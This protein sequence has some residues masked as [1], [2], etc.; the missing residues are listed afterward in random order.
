[1]KFRTRERA[2][3]RGKI[4]FDSLDTVYYT[5]NLL[6]NFY[7]L[8]DDS[9]EMKYLLLFFSIFLAIVGQFFLKKGTSGVDLVATPISVLKAVFSPL[10][11]F[12][13]AV[14][15][16]S[17]VIWLFVLK[18]LPLS[19]AYPAM[20]LSYLFILFLSWRFLGESLG[21][22]KIFGVVLIVF[23]VYCVFK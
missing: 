2:R 3:R 19:T 10:V 9:L 5:K 6:Y 20:S 11:F 23:G 18:R 22:A 14:Y 17:S 15:G 8:C 1:M 13:F 7:F 16:F 21:L 12:G 4:A